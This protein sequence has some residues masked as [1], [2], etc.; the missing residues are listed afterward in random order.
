MFARQTVRELLGDAGQVGSAG[1]FMQQGAGPCFAGSIVIIIV[2]PPPRPCGV[3]PRRRWTDAAGDELAEWEISL[4]LPPPL[5]PEIPRLFTKAFCMRSG[6]MA[7][8][9]GT[10]R[11]PAAPLGGLP[12]S[13]SPGHGSWGGQENLE[14]LPPGLQGFQL[15]LGLF[16]KITLFFFNVGRVG[17]QPLFCMLLYQTT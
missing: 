4:Y 16:L 11:G 6:G 9:R 5:A 3:P 2:L 10:P 15:E 1:L 17:R 14:R 13:C 12:G 7:T 8:G